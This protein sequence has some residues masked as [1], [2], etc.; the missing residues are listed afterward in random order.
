MIYHVII[1]GFIDVYIVV[2]VVWF[3]QR[4]TCKITCVLG[5]LAPSTNTSTGSRVRGNDKQYIS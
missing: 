5:E 3:Q 4:L 2:R 1:G